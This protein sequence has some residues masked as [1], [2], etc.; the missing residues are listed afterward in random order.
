MEAGRECRTRGGKETRIDQ[1]E[2]EGDVSQRLPRTHT[3]VLEVVALQ[4]LSN[5]SG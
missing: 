2:E 5:V 4:K 3:P 1:N